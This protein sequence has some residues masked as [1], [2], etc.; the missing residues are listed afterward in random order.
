MQKRY[1]YI[2]ETG[3]A[4]KGTLAT[5][6][7]PL[8]ISIRLKTSSIDLSHTTAFSGC[9]RTSLLLSDVVLRN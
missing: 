1:T 5:N 8:D 2:N 7:C 3:K 6:V 4:S 9:L